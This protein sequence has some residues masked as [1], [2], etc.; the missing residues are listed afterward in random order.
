CGF[1]DYWY[2]HRR[3]LPSAPSW[4]VGAVMFTA[5]NATST[6][7]LTINTLDPGTVSYQLRA[8]DTGGHT[9]MRPAGAGFFLCIEQILQEARGRFK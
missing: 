8:S 5:R 2:I 7:R 9:A 1:Y 6:L 4:M 3:V